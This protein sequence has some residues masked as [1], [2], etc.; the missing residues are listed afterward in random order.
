MQY[1]NNEIYD[2][3]WLDGLRHGKGI[4]YIS[5]SSK[6]EGNWDSD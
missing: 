2:G 1:V 4:L 3:E 6:Y 5:N